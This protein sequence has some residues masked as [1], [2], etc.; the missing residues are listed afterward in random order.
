[1]KF[2]ESRNISTWNLM[3]GRRE[4]LWG[5][6][7][8]TQQLLCHRFHLEV[9]TGGNPNTPP[10]IWLFLFWTLI[11]WVDTKDFTLLFLLRHRSIFENV[12]EGM[13]RIKK[14]QL[15]D[16]WKL[17]INF[18]KNANFKSNLLK[19]LSREIGGNDAKDC[20]FYAQFYD[21]L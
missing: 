2:F 5:E 1:M 11:R 7:V 10:L 21:W 17:L 16:S 15:E 8:W 3:L 14:I 9:G 20:L 18:K 13:R 12:W 4:R 6:S 19:S